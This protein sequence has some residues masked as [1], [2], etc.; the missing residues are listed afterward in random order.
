M[1]DKEEKG[2]EAREGDKKGMEEGKGGGKKRE[3]SE[4]E[5]RKNR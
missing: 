3:R 2:D 5:I 1:S 4:R